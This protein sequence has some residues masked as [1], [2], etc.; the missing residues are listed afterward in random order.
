M[1]SSSPS[2][3]PEPDAVRVTKTTEGITIITLHRPHRRNAIDIRTGRKL[4]DALRA[5]D[6][7][8]T[9]KV[10][11]IYGAGGTFCA[12]FDLQELAAKSA[13]ARTTSTTS[14]S[15]ST[16]TTTP[17]PDRNLSNGDTSSE[18]PNLQPVSGQN[19]APLGPSRLQLS[20]PLIGAISGHAVAGGLELSLLADLR[21]VEEDAVFGVFCRRFGV[22]LIDGGT[23]RLQAVVGLGRA[24]DMIITGRGVGADEALSMGLANRVVPRGK[25]LEEAMRVAREVV[26][27]PQL[28]LRTDRTSCYFA[29]FEADSMLDALR[30]EFENGV[31][32][33]RRESVQGAKRFRDGI[34]RH[35]RFDGRAKL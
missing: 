26:R 33:V 27:F 35:G 29:A 4:Y 2:P 23:V 17:D 14:T 22:P 30:F 3:D 16:S 6:Q 13:S 1:T 34:G 28:C 18:F 5:F 24:L 12:G 21:I 25:V 20:K 9:Q 7:D 10:G 8:D 11:I 31:K 15:T 19:L 32:V